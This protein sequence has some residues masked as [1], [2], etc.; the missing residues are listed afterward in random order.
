MRLNE[1]LT[2]KEACEE[3]K[4]REIKSGRSR[5]LQL[6]RWNKLAEVEKVGRG[7]YIIHRQITQDEIQENE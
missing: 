3:F 2:Y 6:N 1:E 4:D 5:E 7:K